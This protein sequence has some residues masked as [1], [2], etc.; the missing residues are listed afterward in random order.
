M[1]RRVVPVG[2]GVLEAL[3]KGDVQPFTSTLPA[4]AKVV[5]VLPECGHF[6]ARQR[7]SNV[8][9]ESALWEPVKDGETVPVYHPVMTT[10]PEES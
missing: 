4:D 7:S 5:Y 9:M 8:V 3:L 2:H 1:G 6:G 10:I